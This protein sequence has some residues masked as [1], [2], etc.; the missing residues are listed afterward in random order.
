MII[1][2]LGIIIGFGSI[3]LGNAL[4]GGHL[5][6]L[7]QPTAALIVFG[8]TLGSVLVNVGAADFKRSIKAAIKTLTANPPNYKPLIEQIIDLA[9]VA[10]REGILGLDAKIAE[11]KHPFL[12]KNLRHIVDGYDPGVVKEMMEEAMFIE[13]DEKNAAAK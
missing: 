8:G 3:L 6:S 5:S 7:I 9:S 12:A 2:W 11:I 13:E 10:R 4:E 1:T